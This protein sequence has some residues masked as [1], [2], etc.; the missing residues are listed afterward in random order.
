MFSGNTNKIVLEVGGLCNTVKNIIVS[1]QRFLVYTNEVPHRGAYDVHT[2]TLRNPER[3]TYSYV[4]TV[5]SIRCN[6]RKHYVFCYPIERV[7]EEE[8]IED[9]DRRDS[10]GL[11]HVSSPAVD[12][13]HQ[14]SWM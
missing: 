13:W 14:V 11:M 3:C 4:T 9:Y 8:I 7:N 5:H 2:H 10:R 6:V 1:C 12:G